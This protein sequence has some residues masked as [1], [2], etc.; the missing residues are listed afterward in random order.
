VGGSGAKAAV[1]K[2]L[3]IADGDTQAP[4][5]SSRTAASAARPKLPAW[6]EEHNRPHKQVAL[7]DPRDCR[8]KGEGV[9]HVLLG[10]ARRHNLALTG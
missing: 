5:S 8:L 9:H 3:T 2:T 6:K 4:D 7:E 1:G 10:I